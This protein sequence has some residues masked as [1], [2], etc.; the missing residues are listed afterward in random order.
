MDA[1]PAADAQ[2][3]L[4]PERA[5]EER[6]RRALG[7]RVGSPDLSRAGRHVSRNALAG[8]EGRDSCD[9]RPESARAGSA[10]SRPLAPLSANQALAVLR[11]DGVATAVSVATT[12]DAGETWSAPVP[13]DLP[14]PDAGIDAIHLTDGRVLL[15]FNDS[16]SGRENLRLAISTDDGRTWA[17]V[18]T[19]AEEPGGDFSYPFLMQTRNGDVHLVYTWQRKAIKHVTFNVAWLDERRKINPMSRQ[20]PHRGVRRCLSLARAGAVSAAGG[21]PVSMAAARMDPAAR[22]RRDCGARAAPA[23]RGARDRALGGRPSARTSASP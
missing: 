16:T 1:R 5:G 21:E 23:G 13:L 7:W 22:A 3:V 12:E 6:A 10:I 4:Q 18:A 17:R 9:P 2:S 8:R 20:R 19:L 15:A 14:N 11:D